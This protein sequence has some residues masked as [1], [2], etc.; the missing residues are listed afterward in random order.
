M[1]AMDLMFMPPKI[2]NTEALIP[3]VKVTLGGAFEK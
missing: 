3:H 1:S 2:S